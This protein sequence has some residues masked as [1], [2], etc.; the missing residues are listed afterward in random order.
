[1][2]G[3]PGNPVSAIVTFEILVKPAIR[4]MLGR[5]AIHP[6]TILVRVGRAIE[7]RAGLVRFLRVRLANAEAG[8]PTAEL[9]GNQGSGVLT[10]V[11]RADALLV[12]PLDFDT[13][14][15][16]DVA[17]A[18]PLQEQDAAQIAPGF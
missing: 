17:V 8:L 9:T 18:V 2:F 3:L 10:S 6:P 7:S 1:V 11:A 13:L 5:R 14:E 15:A 12:V 16:G 4:A